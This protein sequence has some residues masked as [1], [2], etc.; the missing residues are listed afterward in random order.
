MKNRS[1]I[2]NEAVMLSSKVHTWRTPE[3]LF[4][5]LNDRFKFTIDLAADKE[6]AL[7]TSFYSEEEDSLKQDW[8][9]KVGWC[10]PPYGREI[11]K[12]TQKAAST[13]LSQGD[14]IVMLLPGRI[15]TNWWHDVKNKCISVFLK[16]RVGFIEP[17]KPKAVSAPFPSMLLVFQNP[18]DLTNKKLGDIVTWDWTSNQ[19][20][21]I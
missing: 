1:T 14:T 21:P 20:F 4:K 9:N 2:Q 15:D 18:K 19:K 8:S 3:E 10:N 13:K 17:N 16:G 12:W 6:S 11:P 5:P 7:C